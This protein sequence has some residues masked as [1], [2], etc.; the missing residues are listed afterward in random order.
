MLS[1]R[2]PRMCRHPLFV[3]PRLDLPDATRRHKNLHSLHL[4]P[5]GVAE[6]NIAALDLHLI[7]WVVWG[8]LGGLGGCWADSIAAKY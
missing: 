7:L 5:K 3:F 2:L 8:C 4:F 1:C 6:E